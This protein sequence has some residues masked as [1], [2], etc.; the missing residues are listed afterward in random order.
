MHSESSNISDSLSDYEKWEFYQ[1]LYKFDLS[2]GLD[3][4]LKLLNLEKN[5]EKLYK[6]TDLFYPYDKN[7]YDKV[8]GEINSIMQPRFNEN[9]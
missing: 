4:F 2:K 8:V 9:Y 7:E 1:E 5:K 3:Q 6:F